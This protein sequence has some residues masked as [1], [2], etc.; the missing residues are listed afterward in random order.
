M[1]MKI[2]RGLLY[3]GVIGLA[4]ICIIAMIDNYQLAINQG[5]TSTISCYNTESFDTNIGDVKPIRQC[6]QYN[7]QVVFFGSIMLLLIDVCMFYFFN[8]L[9]TNNARVGRGFERELKS[10]ESDMKDEDQKRDK[11]KLFSLI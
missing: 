2:A 5:L 6:D 4:M 3:A 9:I 10:L 7:P 1:K 11:K 8:N